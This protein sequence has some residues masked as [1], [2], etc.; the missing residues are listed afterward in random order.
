MTLGLTLN[1]AD[2]RPGDTLTV[3]VTVNN[4]GGPGL[5]DFVFAVLLPDGSTIVSA[6][7]GIGA[8][9]GRVGDLRTL[10]PVA[11]NIGLGALRCW[12]VTVDSWACGYDGLRVT[13]DEPRDLRWSYSIVLTPAR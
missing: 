12:G 3:R 7:P 9:F 10:V 6:G 4:T 13:C 8:R 2:I 1:D 11:R 5:A